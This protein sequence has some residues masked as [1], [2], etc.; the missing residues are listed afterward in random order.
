MGKFKEEHY[1]SMYWPLQLYCFLRQLPLSLPESLAKLFPEIYLSA[2]GDIKSGRRD[3]TLD[4]LSRVSLANFDSKRPPFSFNY[5]KSVSSLVRHAHSRAMLKGLSS[6]KFTGA[7]MCK[8]LVNVVQQLNLKGRLSLDK[9]Y[10]K[11]MK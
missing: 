3:P 9:L 5:M 1:G 2:G 8:L 4:Y 10:H 7:N 11:S 6:L